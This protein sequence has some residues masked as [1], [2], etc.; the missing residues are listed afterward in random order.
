MDINIDGASSTY[1]KDDPRGIHVGHSIYFADEYWQFYYKYI[2]MPTETIDTNENAMIGIKTLEIYRPPTDVTLGPINWEN[3]NITIIN[4]S[5]KVSI[6]F[7]FYDDDMSSYNETINVGGA[8]NALFKITYGR[9][10]NIIITRDDSISEE[11]YNP[12]NDMAFNSVSY[13][14]SYFLQLVAYNSGWSKTSVKKY[15]D[16]KAPVTVVADVVIP[17]G[18]S[19]DNLGISNTDMPLARFYTSLTTAFS[20][21]QLT[22]TLSSNTLDSPTDNMLTDI[23]YPGLNIIKNAI[24][25][26]GYNLDNNAKVIISPKIIKQ[27]V[28]DQL[29]YVPKKINGASINR[30]QINPL[31]ANAVIH[32]PGGSMGGMYGYSLFGGSSKNSSNPYYDNDSEQEIYPFGVQLTLNRELYNH[33]VRFIDFDSKNFTVDDTKYTY[34]I[35]VLGITGAHF[36]LNGVVTGKYYTKNKELQDK[37][38]SCH[39]VTSVPLIGM[40][41]RGTSQTYGLSKDIMTLKPGAKLIMC[42]DDYDKSSITDWFESRSTG[43]SPLLIS[44]VFST[45]PSS[46]TNFI[47]DPSTGHSISFSK[48]MHTP[49]LEGDHFC[50]DPIF[51]NE[52]NNTIYLR[53]LTINYQQWQYALGDGIGEFKNFDFSIYAID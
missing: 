52:S 2:N 11:N 4:G 13:D 9:I 17:N 36:T 32:T 42:V 18:L 49:T 50:F 15:Y 21:I 40:D 26:L 51:T 46:S 53:Y 35:H 30:E 5:A 39:S 38:D 47:G 41:P 8:E 43:S 3:R 29:Y 10:K 31:Y 22:K 48:K 45:D 25:P 24:Y 28:A 14:Y 33:Y 34:N 44:Y 16:E 6:K 19:H 20:R 37:Y 1:K 7:E 12:S 23:E 27:S